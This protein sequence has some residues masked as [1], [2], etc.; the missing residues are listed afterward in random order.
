MQWSRLYAFKFPLASSASLSLLGLMKRTGAETGVGPSTGPL[1]VSSLEAAL[2]E[3]SDPGCQES[4]F[5]GMRQRAIL[6]HR[7]WQVSKFAGAHVSRSCVD[8][9]AT[10]AARNGWDFEPPLDHPAIG[11]D[12]F[13][14]KAPADYS[15]ARPDCLR[16]CVGL[17]DQPTQPAQQAG[18]D[19]PWKDPYRRCGNQ[20]A[21]VRANPLCGL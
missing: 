4:G 2:S 5:T 10:G 6:A 7:D 18:I 20:T 12:L 21:V 16:R 14:N 13:Q 11:N 8:Q 3:I 17:S 15:I 19:R 9:A 1:L